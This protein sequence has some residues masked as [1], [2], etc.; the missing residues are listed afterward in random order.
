MKIMKYCKQIKAFKPKNSLQ[1]D[2]LLFIICETLFKCIKP[3]HNW[4]K[5]YINK[6]LFMIDF[7]Y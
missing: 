7:Y 3:Y 5:W 4:V 1:I 2:L 6:K